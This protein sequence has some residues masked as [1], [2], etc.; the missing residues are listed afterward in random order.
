MNNVCFVCG[1]EC[2]GWIFLDEN[3]VLLVEVLD[4]MLN[5]CVMMNR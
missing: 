4:L 1:D 5:D 2:V 3:G